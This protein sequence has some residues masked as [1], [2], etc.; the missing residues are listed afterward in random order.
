MTWECP[1]CL[2]TF[3]ITAKRNRSASE[4][5]GECYR[6]VSTSSGKYSGHFITPSE[7]NHSAHRCALGP[8]ET[9][10]RL[11]EEE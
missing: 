1:T 7:I 10:N 2:M 3:K 9:A 11:L 4:V 5:C 6:R 8:L